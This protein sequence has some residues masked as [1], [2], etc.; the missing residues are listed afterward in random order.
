MIIIKIIA[1]FIYLCLFS[2]CRRAANAHANRIARNILHLILHTVNNNNPVVD[3]SMDHFLCRLFFFCFRVMMRESKQLHTAH[4]HGCMDAMGCGLLS[5]LNL[6]LMATE[7]NMS[8]SYECGPPKAINETAIV[9]LCAAHGSWHAFSVVFRVERLCV[10]RAID[11]PLQSRRIERPSSERC[12]PE[13]SLWMEKLLR[14]IEYDVVRCICVFA[15][16]RNVHINYFENCQ[17]FFLCYY[18]LCTIY[19]TQY[20][21]LWR[22]ARAFRLMKII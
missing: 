6:K 7:R 4:V 19:R 10:P 14:T 1:K 11:L 8:H 22:S 13:Q 17:L 18:L 16:M 2:S 15:H 3:R 21:W 12:L 5:L 9:A 20:V